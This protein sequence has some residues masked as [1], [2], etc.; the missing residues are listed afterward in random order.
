MRLT[1][2]AGP[3]ALAGL[4]CIAPLARRH[5]DEVVGLVAD[6]R[7]FVPHASRRAGRASTLTAPRD[8]PSGATA[9]VRRRVYETA[10]AGRALRNDADG[11]MRAVMVVPARIRLRGHHGATRHLEP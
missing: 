4:H 9:G 8:V 1:S 3:V 5:L 7:R 10:E 2:T 11:A 6:K